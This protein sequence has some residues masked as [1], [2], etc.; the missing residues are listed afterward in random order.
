MYLVFG[1]RSIL[2]LDNFNLSDKKQI[3]KEWYDGF[4][5]GKQKIFIIRGR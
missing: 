4:T 1:R 5:F 2:A 3:V